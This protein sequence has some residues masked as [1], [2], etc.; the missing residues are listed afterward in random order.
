[1]KFVLLVL[2][3]AFSI[4]SCSNKKKGQVNGQ[5]YTIIP[6]D[7]TKNLIFETEKFTGVILDKEVRGSSIEN[8]KRFTPTPE[9]VFKAENI[10]MRC[11]EVDKITIDGMEIRPHSLYELRKYFRQYLGYWDSNG[12]K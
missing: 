6:M 1:M 5:E 2:F 7:S 11:V 3:L 10:L 9:Q 12:Q 4:C 8:Y